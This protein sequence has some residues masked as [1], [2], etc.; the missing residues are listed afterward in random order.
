MYLWFTHG[1]LKKQGPFSDACGEENDIFRDIAHR[2]G[3]DEK[4]NYYGGTE[5]YNSLE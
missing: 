2:N 3:R 5:K 1:S 4:Q